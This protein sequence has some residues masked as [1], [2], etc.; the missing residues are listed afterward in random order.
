MLSMIIRESEHYKPHY[1]NVKIL[2][3]D[4]FVCGLVAWWSDNP[5]KDAI[6]EAKKCVILYESY[7]V[8]VKRIVTVNDKPVFTSE[9][10]PL[11]EKLCKN[12]I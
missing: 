1:K 11:R 7:G 9:L 4:G 10:H 8:A 12:Y 6:S 3:E 5:I 2:N